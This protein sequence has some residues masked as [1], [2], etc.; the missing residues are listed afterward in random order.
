[1]NHKFGAVYHLHIIM[2]ILYMGL[3]ALDRFSRPQGAVILLQRGGSGQGYVGTR[4]VSDFIPG[5]FG[6]PGILIH[7]VTSSVAM[8]VIMLRALRRPLEA[9]AGP[10]S[11]ST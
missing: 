5:L 10:P 11:R 1:M 3:K 6:R 2:P 4:A 8:V 7:R 9:R